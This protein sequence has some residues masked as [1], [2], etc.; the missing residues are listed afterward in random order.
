MTIKNFLLANKNSFDKKDLEIFLEKVL[1]CDKNFLFLNEDFFLSHKKIVKLY[2][3]LKK[4]KEWFSVASIIWEKFFYW[5]KFFVNKNV[6]IPRE[7]TEDLIKFIL[8][9][10]LDIKN[11][12]LSNNFSKNIL[13]IWT[14]SW[15]IPI[16][17]K[18]E[19][20]NKNINF[21]ASD[22]SNKALKVAKK[23]AKNFWVKIKFFKSD[24]L[25]KLP[26]KLKNKEIFLITANLPYVEENFKT[27]TTAK[28]LWILKEPD[29]A[30]YSWE[31]WLNHYKKL[32]EELKYI[33]F[34]YLIMEMWSCQTDKIADLYSSIWNTEIYYDL[35]WNKR[36]VFVE[37][38]VK[39]K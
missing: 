21:F 38:V 34:K 17:L 16:T 36:W 19:L 29:L 13:D 37:N 4:R 7:E 20:K 35:G 30:L 9:K 14:W 39:Q 31:D 10:K 28:K 23:N 25:K 2:K 1:E 24:L 5:R 3:F 8:D 6:L 18:L 26:S 32:L 27:A 33:K 15:I 22:I 12:N 11:N